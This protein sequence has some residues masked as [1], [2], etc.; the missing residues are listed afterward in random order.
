MKKPREKKELIRY[1]ITPAA[2]IEFGWLV[3]VGAIVA[4]AGVVRLIR[5]LVV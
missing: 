5:W 2:F 1:G 4:A 3:F